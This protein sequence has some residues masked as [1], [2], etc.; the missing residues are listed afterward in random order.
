MTKKKLTKDEIVKMADRCYRRCWNCNRYEPHSG[1]VSYSDILFRHS[2]NGCYEAHCL[3]WKDGQWC[4]YWGNKNHPDAKI[5]KALT[6]S[7][8][9]EY[10]VNHFNEEP[11][12][13]Q[14]ILDV[15]PEIAERIKYCD[16]SNESRIQ[17]FNKSENWT[18]ITINDGV[19]IYAETLRRYRF[20]LVDN[21]LLY[22]GANEWIRPM[23]L[24]FHPRTYQIMSFYL[25]SGDGIQISFACSPNE[26]YRLDANIFQYDE[27][28][29]EVRAE[30]R[31]GGK[32]LESHLLSIE[33]YV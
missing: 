14:R 21:R 31:S 28:K 7:N 33:S 20:S 22:P 3:P 27:V 13:R 8:V 9:A 6:W 12:L 32:I 15:N 10:S 24:V 23:I 18:L 4:P 11:E 16:N 30:F 25:P 26:N 29:K 1:N 5:L 2:N 19:E 17:Y